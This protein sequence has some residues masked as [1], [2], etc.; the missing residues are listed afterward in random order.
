M[1]Q[2]S[3]DKEY[4]KE[5]IVRKYVDRHT[6]CPRS[7]QKSQT[8]HLRHTFVAEAESTGC[9]RHRTAIRV[10]QYRRVAADSTSGDSIGEYEGEQA[11]K[12]LMYPGMPMR[13]SISEVW[14]GNKGKR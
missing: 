6:A 8:W 10:Y 14:R 4:V 5:N 12:S 11:A 7:Q 9:S 1:M 13:S 3:I 2:I